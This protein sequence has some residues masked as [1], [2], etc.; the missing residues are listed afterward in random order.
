MQILVYFRSTEDPFQPHS[1]EGTVGMYLCRECRC[2]SKCCYNG[3]LLKH[4]RYIYHLHAKC[5]TLRLYSG[6]I[7]PPGS[8]ARLQKKRKKAIEQE[9][10]IEKTG[11]PQ[12]SPKGEAQMSLE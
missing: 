8:R 5:G 6:G 2:I 11:C 4:H 10:Y 7:V 12:V 9:L 3:N 1:V